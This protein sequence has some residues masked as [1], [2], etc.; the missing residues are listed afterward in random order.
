MREKTACIPAFEPGLPCVQ[1]V[2]SASHTGAK[3]A[4]TDGFCPGLFHS[5]T[6]SFWDFH[7][8]EEKMEINPDILQNQYRSDTM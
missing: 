1:R 4:C 7:A 5:W 2:A 6:S 8:T 3:C